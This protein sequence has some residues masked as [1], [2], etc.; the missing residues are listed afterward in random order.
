MIKK[1]LKNQKVTIKN[2]KNTLEFI[3]RLNKKKLYYA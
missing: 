2:L 1:A 3:F